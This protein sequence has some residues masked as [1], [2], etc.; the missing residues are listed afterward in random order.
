MAVPSHRILDRRQFAEQILL[1]L[2]LIADIA[3]FSDPRQRFNLA[4]EAR[5]EP[6][7]QWKYGNKE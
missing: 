1:L 4:T 5:D 7:H 2:A 3:S 6:S